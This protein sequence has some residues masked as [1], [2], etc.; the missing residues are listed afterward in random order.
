MLGNQ[1]SY[2]NGGESLVTMKILFTLIL[3]LF[4]VFSGCSKKI[5]APTNP[6]ENM[7]DTT[8]FVVKPQY[9]IP[10][11]SLTQTA[12]PKALHDAQCTGRSSF[13]G[14]L[15]GHL[16]NVI[17]LGMYTTDPVIG[18][19][20]I[21]YIASDSNLYAYTTSGKSL[22]KTFI[23]ESNGTANYNSPI[24]NSDGTIFIGTGNGF[25]A[26]NKDGVLKWNVRLDGAVVIKSSAIGL[27]GHIY[28]IT[29]S[30]T[31]YAIAKNGNILWHLTAPAGYFMWGS[32]ST[33][34]FSPDGGR[35]YV[36]GSTAD[37]SLYEIS[38]AGTI[39]RTDSLGGG[40]DGAISVDV[41][42]N[43]YGYFGG[44]LVS[45]SPS[46]KVRWRKSGVGTNWN[47]VIDP[48]GNIACLSYGNLILLDN[49]GQERWRIPVHK[50]DD[51]THLVC[52]ANGTIFIETS[53]DRRNYDVQ[54]I[55][56]DGKVLW[57]LTVVAYVKS[58]GPSLTKDGYLLF[59][60][61]GYYPTP[62]EIYVIE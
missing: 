49:I 44:S 50:V 27:D 15:E 56:N 40:Q 26:F 33:I 4:L 62:K 19:D 58:G 36:G 39:L 10:W 55:S 45:I 51:I 17:S 47:V 46:G 25:S 60:H 53:E 28:T 52:D 32:Q 42:G 30:K 6:P 59:P 21:I 9:D 5:V 11:P 1:H 12:W 37:Q 2:H 7:P 24:V 61:S 35:L 16:K 8:N 34:S 57:T 41:D 14:P 31:L 54:A 3:Y 48:F 18:Q 22:W 20:S 13:A 29:S 23:G 38:T 43:I